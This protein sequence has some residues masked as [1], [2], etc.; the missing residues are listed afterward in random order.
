MGLGATSGCQTLEFH[1]RG[2]LQ[3]PVMAFDESRA[4][5]HWAQKVRY[6][7]EGSVGGI[8]VSAG[9]GCGCF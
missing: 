8:G 5:V 6:S 9:G 4:E 1:E 3:D 2:R 7:R